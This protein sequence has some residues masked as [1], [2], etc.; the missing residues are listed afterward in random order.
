MQTSPTLDQFAQGL[1]EF[2]RKENE[3]KLLQQQQ[4]QQKK[5]QTQL[6]QGSPIITRNV[7]LDALYN[8]S[9]NH[10]GYTNPTKN[11][12]DLINFA[13]DTF[14]KIGDELFSIMNNIRVQGSKI[15]V[16]QNTGATILVFLAAI[17]ALLDEDTSIL[18]TA[19]NE[20]ENKLGIPHSSTQNP[21]IKSET[22]DISMGG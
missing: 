20:I 22:Q 10:L 9:T 6:Q 8:F 3:L 5:Q 15:T 21:S 13:T 16:P 14:K 4:E 19:R 18:T 11:E 12:T 2:E 17:R 1:E 7:S